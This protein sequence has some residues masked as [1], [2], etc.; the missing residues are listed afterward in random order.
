MW[1][2]PCF[3]HCYAMWPVMCFCSSHAPSETIQFPTGTTIRK[4]KVHP[5]SFQI[6]GGKIAM[7]SNITALCYYRES[8]KEIVSIALRYSY[9]TRAQKHH[10]M[11][12]LNNLRILYLFTTQECIVKFTLA[13]SAS[14]MP[15][16]HM[17]AP[18]LPDWSLSLWS[19]LRFDL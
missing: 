13:N 18:G 1:E 11:F 5:E 19:G 2:F 15:M 14:S 8:T 7:F 6:C 10:V 4:K 16:T 12:W 3:A 9:T 17:R